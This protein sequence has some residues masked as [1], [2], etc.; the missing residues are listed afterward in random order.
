M[1]K[2]DPRLS[3]LSKRSDIKKGELNIVY[4]G[5]IIAFVGVLLFALCGMAGTEYRIT[6]PDCK[7]TIADVIGMILLP[8][9][10]F[11]LTMMAWPEVLSFTGLL[12]FLSAIFAIGAGIVLLIMAKDFIL[13]LVIK[14][15]CLA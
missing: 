7:S 3:K 11:G 8:I 14:F 15:G 13:G 9:I 12:K 2:A 10:V 6:H 1:P 4:C 5:A